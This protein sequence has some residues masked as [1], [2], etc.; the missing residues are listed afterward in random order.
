MPDS[1]WF[2]CAPLPPFCP[3][4][5]LSSDWALQLIGSPVPTTRSQ[6]THSSS[7]DAPTLAQ[8]PLWYDDTI[9]IDKMKLRCTDFGTSCTIDV[10]QIQSNPIWCSNFHRYSQVL[11]QMNLFDT[12]ASPWFKITL[13]DLKI[14]SFE[15]IGVCNIWGMIWGKKIRPAY[16]AAV[17]GKIIW[18]DATGVISTV[19]VKSDWS[20]LKIRRGF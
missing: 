3:N 8:P 11:N 12:R 7:D 6:P 4:H 20:W 1:D 5:L 19:V 9:S 16:L 18:L 15:P 2:E 17:F 13:V 10:S 14:W